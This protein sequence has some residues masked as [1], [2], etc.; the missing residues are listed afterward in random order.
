MLSPLSA[1]E[2]LAK[3]SIVLSE[4]GWMLWGIDAALGVVYL[5]TFSRSRSH[6]RPPLGPAADFYA[7]VV[8][9]ML[10]AAAFVCFGLDLLI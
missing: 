9:P 7:N 8:A 3:E 5:T 2:F 1:D 4:I 10:L 6:R